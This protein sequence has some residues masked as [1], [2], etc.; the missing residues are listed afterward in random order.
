MPISSTQ[1]LPCK[2]PVTSARRVSDNANFV[3]IQTH[4]VW[5]FDVR[6]V[7]L[8]FPRYPGMCA[9]TS[10]TRPIPRRRSSVATAQ[11]AAGVSATCAP[12]AGHAS[13]MRAAVGFANTGHHSASGST[14]A[15][16]LLDIIRH[17][18]CGGEHHRHARASVE[19]AG[20]TIFHFVTHGIEAVLEQ[21]IGRHMVD[22]G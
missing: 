20:G 11:M 16:E 12:P 18:V 3:V 17:R 21:A 19:M 22:V 4:L 2:K 9:V 1:G 15:H 10:V 8:A 14:P 13:W 7:R 6:R 5:G